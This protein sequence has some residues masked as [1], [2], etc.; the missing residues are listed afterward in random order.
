MFVDAFARAAD[1]FAECALQI[2]EAGYAL[3]FGVHDEWAAET[4]DTDEYTADELARM[5][6]A[7]LGW[8]AGLPL[9]TAGG[10]MYRYFKEQ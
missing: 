2:E 9:A 8:N 4:P 10:E 5:M 7:D 3:I 6:C 1:Q